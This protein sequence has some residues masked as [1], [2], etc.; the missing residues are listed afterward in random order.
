MLRNEAEVNESNEKKIKSFEKN[1]NN[2][3]PQLSEKKV[4]HTYSAL[5]WMKNTQ[6][7]KLLA[8]EQRQRWQPKRLTEWREKISPF[9][10]TYNC[11]TDTGFSDD[12]VEMLD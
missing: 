1:N 3:V 11:H 7:F 2:I 5:T 9:K 4:K 8:N 10:Q 12:F 6:N